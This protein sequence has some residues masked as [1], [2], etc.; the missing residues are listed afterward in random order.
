MQFMKEQHVFQVETE[1]G[2]ETAVVELQCLQGP[3]DRGFLICTHFIL[4]TGTQVRAS[5]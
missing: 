3:G 5:W 2:K 4:A 1:G